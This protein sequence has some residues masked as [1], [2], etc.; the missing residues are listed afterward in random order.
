M[1]QPANAY[2]NVAF[3]AAAAHV[4]ALGWGDAQLQPGTTQAHAEV[5]RFP[6]FT[7][8]YGLALV[9]PGSAPSCCGHRLCAAILWHKRSVSL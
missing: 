3:L 9:R 6:A 4:L 5:Q 8:L 1:A 2:S 7:L